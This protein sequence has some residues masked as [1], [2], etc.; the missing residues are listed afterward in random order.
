MQDDDRDTMSVAEAA[1]VLGV[2][3]DAIRKRLTRGTLSGVKRGRQWRVY[4]QDNQ[5]ATPDATDTPE[6]ADD[7]RSVIEDLRTR[8]DTSDARV[9]TLIT[10]LRQE[11]ERADTLQA[12]NIQH[13]DRIRELEAITATV[14]ENEAVESTETGDSDATH[15]GTHVSGDDRAS[16]SQGTRW[17]RFKRWLSGK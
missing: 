11:R 7:L 1:A 3:V 9:D 12:L 6:H 16:D 2:S 5:H 14:G 4:L 10:D 13:R 17:D 15:I 8:L